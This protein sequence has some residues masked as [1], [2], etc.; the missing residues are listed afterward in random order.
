M[1]TFDLSL[2]K[3]YDLENSRDHEQKSQSLIFKPEP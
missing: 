3:A 1:R 2:I